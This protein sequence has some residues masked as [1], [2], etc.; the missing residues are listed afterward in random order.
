MQEE[1]ARP[2][3]MPDVRNADVADR[4]GFGGNLVPDAECGEEA[5]AGEGDGSGAT[6]EARLG[7]GG[8]WDA[9]DEG[10]S[11]DPLRRLPG[12]EGCR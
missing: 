12:R 4:L 3:V 9:V 1:R 8:E 11:K 5:L 6:V 7:E 10:R 2:A